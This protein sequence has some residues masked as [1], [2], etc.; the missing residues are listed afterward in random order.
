MKAEE[1]GMKKKETRLRE[2]LNSREGGQSD[3]E[4]GHINTSVFGFISPIP[5]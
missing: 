5:K 4:D 3:A 2:G 1:A